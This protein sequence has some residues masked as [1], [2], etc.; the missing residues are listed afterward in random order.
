VAVHAVDLAF[1]ERLGPAL[2]LPLHA[3]RKPE[4]AIDETGRPLDPER[5]AAVKLET[6]I[7]D[8]LPLAERTLAVEVDRAEEFGPVKSVE[9]A[10]TPEKARRMMSAKAARWLERAGAKG[11]RDDGGDP[12]HPIEIS[13]LTALEPEDLSSLVKGGLAFDGPLVL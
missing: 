7:F 13:P 3:A 5:R 4:R 9:G 6:F 2:A 10:D 1:A 11:I 8:V 12:A